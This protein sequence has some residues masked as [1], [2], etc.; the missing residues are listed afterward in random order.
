MRD[1]LVLVA[2]GEIYGARAQIER[3]IVGRR[4]GFRQYLFPGRLRVALVFPAGFE[5][6]DVFIDFAAHV[7][8][9]LTVEVGFREFQG[10]LQ[11]FRRLLFL[12]VAAQ[13]F[14]NR[15]EAE[16]V[17]YEVANLRGLEISQGNVV[18]ALGANEAVVQVGYCE[19]PVF[20]EGLDVFDAPIVAPAG[21]R[22][23]LLEDAQA[24]GK[25]ARDQVIGDLQ[26]DDVRVLVPE[27]APPVDL[28]VARRR[29][30]QRDDLAEADTQRAEPRQAERANGEVFV[31][32]EN[33]DC[34]RRARREFVFRR[35][36]GFCLVQQ[37]DGVWG[38]DVTL[39]RVGLDNEIAVFRLAVLF[40][41]VEQVER[42]LGPDVERVALERLLYGRAS[43]FDL[44]QAQQAHSQS[45]M[46]RPLVGR[47]LQRLDQ[48]GDGFA[49][50]ARLGGEM[51]HRLVKRSVSRVDAERRFDLVIEVALFVLQP[52]H[53]R[54]QAVG[55][56]RIGVDL[57][58]LF[59]QLCRRLEAFGFEV[60]CGGEGLGLYVVRIDLERLGERG[61]HLVASLDPLVRGD[62][63]AP[64]GAVGIDLQRVVQEFG[65]LL[66]VVFRGVKLSA[67]QLRLDAFFV[68]RDRFEIDVVGFLVSFEMRQGARHQ[69][70][71]LRVRDVFLLVI[72]H[73][74]LEDF[75]RWLRGA[76]QLQNLCPAQVGAQPD[77]LLIGLFIRLLVGLRRGLII[78]LARDL[79]RLLKFADRLGVATRSRVDLAER[80]SC[81]AD[82]AR[83]R[84]VSTSGEKFLRVRFGLGVLAGLQ[85]GLQQTFLRL[86]V[87]RVGLKHF[88]EREDG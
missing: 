26:R 79:R 14:E 65:G 23:V 34:D 54:A 59:D 40:H 57:Q 11:D 43:L 45:Q 36:F 71:R 32:R 28:S 17:F 2:R 47:E 51:G 50:A 1:G 62:G 48:E 87:F 37:L 63:Q 4:S 27:R 18:R 49:V 22:V 46:R 84:V 60:D 68:R 15:V 33:F 42:V 39:F 64:A 82:M 80:Q 66:V 5:R 10:L 7:V 35:E 9:E 24:F 58:R 85:I 41:S 16:A 6:L 12:L 78:G 25:P 21:P 20:G 55:F 56:E 69:R 19:P 61:V 72:F 70:Q 86:S 38:Q 88:G 75:P 3:E 81:L 44:A 31:V 74:R 30:I 53:R 77:K 29:R 73:E 8:I 13:H 83:L 52:E 76:G 67:A